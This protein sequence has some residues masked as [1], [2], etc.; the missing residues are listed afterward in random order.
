[1][2]F[3][4][5]GGAGEPV[6][7]P[8]E[9]D[10]RGLV[11]AAA[12]EHDLVGLGRS[13]ELDAIPVPVTPEVRHGDEGRGA[14]REERVDR[15]AVSLVRRIRPVLQPHREVHDTVRPVRD[16]PGRVH[17]GHGGTQILVADDAAVDRMQCETRVPQPLRRG[18]RT[19]P[20]DHDIGE[21][22]LAVAQAKV[23][24]TVP[25]DDLIDRG[26]AQEPGPV[27]AVDA[28]EGA[29]DLVADR[30]YERDR[31]RL[32]DRDPG[33]FLAGRGRDLRADEAR[34][35]DHDVA[36]RNDRRTK[37]R[38][39]VHRPQ[40]VR[41]G[42]AP[43]LRDRA[44]ARA[45]RHQEPP[46]AEHVAVGCVDFVGD[47]IEPGRARREA[48]VDREFDAELVLGTEEVR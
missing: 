20:D 34:S 8:V 36:V 45:R 19:D 13:H 46:V 5:G 47:G 24:D 1:M 29:T 15:S 14:V 31:R 32:D 25:A 37:S 48:K 44:G 18:R 3:V 30:A 4:D 7:H 39:V 43:E 27:A 2:W 11:L 41:A 33:S 16:V 42:P 28:R 22:R 17:V 23:G 21:H 38:R 9:R 26:S 10:E 12:G 40:C 35:D 6:S